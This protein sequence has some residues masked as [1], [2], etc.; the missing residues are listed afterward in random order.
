MTTNTWEVLPDFLS[1]FDCSPFLGHY[2]ESVDFKKFLARQ[3]ILQ[4]FLP[5]KVCFRLCNI[6]LQKILLVSTSTVPSSP[7]WGNGNPLQYA[8]LENP[9][10]RGA[11][12]ATGHRV[13]KSRTRLSDWACTCMHCA[14]LVVSTTCGS[15]VYLLVIFSSKELPIYIFLCKQW[16]L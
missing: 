2:A 10:D 4:Q 13:A 7:G 14:F 5:W 9:M 11:W 12:Q 6:N 1:W 8:C 15:Q 3:F 16:I